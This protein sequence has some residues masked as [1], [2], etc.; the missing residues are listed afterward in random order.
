MNKKS[1]FLIT[2]VVLMLVAGVYY[3]I[4]DESPKAPPAQ[5]AN[6]D[7]QIMSYSGNS[8]IEEQ[9]GKRL[10]ELG[11]E[12]IEID[13]KTKQAVMKN[14]KGVFYQDNGG[15]LEIVALQAIYD[16]KT[17]D[18]VMS[19]QIKATSSDGAIFTADSAR[20]AGGNR[21][22]YGTG[23]ITVTRDDTTIFGDRIE[24]D[25]NMQKIKVEGNARIRKGGSAN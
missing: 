13:P 12:T 22:F 14:L 16:T 21:R 3:F 24:S 6:N 7:Q 19:G 23:G 15:K 1:M 4:R 25:A 8:I 5:V 9:D 11:A 18:I 10:W 17:R 20:W 2:C